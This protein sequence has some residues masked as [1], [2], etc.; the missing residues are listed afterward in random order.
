MW[1]SLNFPQPKG[2]LG[3]YPKHYRGASAGDPD[4]R[5]DAVQEDNP[6]PGHMDAMLHILHN[7][8][9]T[10]GPHKDPEA[11]GIPGHCGQG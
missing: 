3:Q 2:K 4:G 10:V 7:Y 8:V 1:T 5:P 9:A 6:R 11:D